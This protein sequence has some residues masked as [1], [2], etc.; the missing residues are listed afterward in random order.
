MNASHALPYPAPT[1]ARSTQDPGIS[2]RWS[3]HLMKTALSLLVGLPLLLPFLGGGSH[4]LTGT[5]VEQSLRAQ[6]N[7]SPAGQ[8]TKRVDC[9]RLVSVE[10]NG[11]IRYA[12]ALVGANGS[13]SHVV[14]HVTGQTWRADWAPLKG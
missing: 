14:V 12:C 10:Q 3:H 5:Q 13:R 8:I 4:A 9:S 2:R 1:G 7:G 6:M 11:S